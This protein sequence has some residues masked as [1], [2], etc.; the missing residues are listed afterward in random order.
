MR[1]PTSPDDRATFGGR[2]GSRR[3]TPL[4]PGAEGDGAAHISVG[5]RADRQ[6]RHCRVD[7][8]LGGSAEQAALFV[9]ELFT[10]ETLAALAPAAATGLDEVKTRARSSSPYLSVRVE[11]EIS[12]ARGGRAANRHQLR[13]RAAPHA[14]LLVRGRRGRLKCGDRPAPLEARRGSGPPRR[15]APRRSATKQSAPRRHRHQT[16]ADRIPP[17]ASFLVFE[18]GCG[19]T[20]CASGGER[21]RATASPAALRAAPAIARPHADLRLASTG[22]VRTMHHDWLL[23]FAPRAHAT[24]LSDG[25]SP[26]ARRVRSQSLHSSL[27]RLQRDGSAGPDRR[28]RPQ[29]SP[30]RPAS[31]RR[32]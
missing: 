6:P 26:S 32:V 29:A 18:A 12:C 20:D 11:M 19:V 15:P 8:I 24:H 14:R 16:G 3:R 13:D 30:G 4:V 9:D 31:L 7:E 10:A 21:R 28:P 1:A 5:G 27:A 2:T 17:S 22:I 25:Q 23:R